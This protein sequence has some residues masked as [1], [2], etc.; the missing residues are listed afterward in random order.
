MTALKWWYRLQPTNLGVDIFAPAI[1]YCNRMYFIGNSIGGGPGLANVLYALDEDLD[2]G[3]ADCQ[4]PDVG[5][6][7][8]VGVDDG[9]AD[10]GIDGAL[11]DVEAQDSLDA[12]FDGD[13]GDAGAPETEALRDTSP[14]ETDAGV[15]VVHAPG[16]GA[17]RWGCESGFS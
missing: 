14:H 2:G 16:A 15:E 1:G 12:G 9:T 10:S 11:E 17:R 3:V 5:I 7:Y 6:N 4:Y 13:E 8:D